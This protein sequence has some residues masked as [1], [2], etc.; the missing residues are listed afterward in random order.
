MEGEF[1]LFEGGL[2]PLWGGLIPLQGINRPF[3]GIKPLEGVINLLGE[4]IKPPFWG[5]IKL[6]EVVINLG[7]GI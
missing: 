7:G 5:E 2:N 3:G 1:S 4:G 6:L